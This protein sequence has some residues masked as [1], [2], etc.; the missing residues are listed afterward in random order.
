MALFIILL[1]FALKAYYVTEVVKA[2]IA[3]LFLILEEMLSVCGC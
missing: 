1:S 3:T 2:G